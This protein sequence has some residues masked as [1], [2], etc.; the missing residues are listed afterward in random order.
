MT[1]ALPPF[2][3]LMKEQGNFGAFQVLS[4]LLIMT[5]L[6]TN[7]YIIYQFAYLL[8]YPEVT[9]FDKISKAPV[10]GDECKPDYFCV[11][12]HNVGY[13]II[14]DSELTL[15]NW[16]TD[17]DLLCASKF[18]ISSFAMAF[19]TGFALGSF[20]LPQQ[21][22]VHGRKKP[23]FLC[24]AVQLVA[25]LV[26]IFVPYH[27]QSSVTILQV[28][29]LVLGLSSAGRVAIGFCYMQEFQPLSYQSAISSI[30]NVS[31]G[32]VYIYLTIYYKYI[33]KD[34]YWTAVVP[35]VVNTLVLF[36][37]VYLPESPKWLYDQKRYKDC[38]IVLEKMAKMNKT[39]KLPKIASLDEVDLGSIDP[40]H[41]QSLSP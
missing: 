2:A 8:L 6:N 23:F 38:R 31:E 30:W 29:M 10:E 13:E 33:D 27:K 16:I 22:D 18:T 26:V 37:L 12:D 34:W 25:L 36:A 32:A 39:N 41:L 35:T 14:E 3:D 9:C 5:T 4:A 11:A 28:C 20:F 7:G 1:A 19:F 17:F 40:K 15:T 21:A 24:M